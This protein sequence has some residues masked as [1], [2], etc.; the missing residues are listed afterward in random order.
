VNALANFEKTSSTLIVPQRG[1]MSILCGG[2]VFSCGFQ[3]QPSELA[4]KHFG[5]LEYVSSSAD[6][7]HNPVVN[8]NA[9]LSALNFDPA[10]FNGLKYKASQLY[11]AATAEFFH[12]V[13]ADFAASNSR[14]YAYA[15]VVPQGAST[16]SP[17]LTAVLD[18]TSDNQA[19][20][21]L[22]S[23]ESLSEPNWDGYGAQPI[24]RETLDY[25]RRLIEI[26]PQTFGP[27][28]VAP[29]GDG[30]IALEWVPEAGP[31]HK[32]FLDIGPGEEGRAYWKR[33][34]GKFDRLPGA[35]FTADTKRLLRELFDS[36]SK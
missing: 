13:D 9:I 32:L 24:S 25:A 12:A 33:R 14:L 17:L 35:G 4:L 18:Q 7:D 21:A 22:A 1:L 15:F 34:N 5:T 6:P 20:D 10:F 28:D 30:S 3:S 23:Y 19:L 8:T 11:T 27:P 2:L 26:M 31:I 16:A 29:S 36:L